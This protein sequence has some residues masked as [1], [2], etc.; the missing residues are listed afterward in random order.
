ME[1]VLCVG[2]LKDGVWI[3]VG[4]SATEHVFY[5]SPSLFDEVIEDWSI[6]YR[7]MI[8]RANEL[9]VPIFVPHNQSNEDTLRMLIANYRKSNETQ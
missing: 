5:K 9:R 4:Q 6:F 1:K 8:W 2:G 7:R 3:S